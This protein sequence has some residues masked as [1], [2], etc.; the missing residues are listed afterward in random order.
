[1]PEFLTPHALEQFVSQYGYWAVFVLVG[2]ENAGIPLPGEIV[3]VAAAIDAGTTGHLR[4]LPV[5]LAAAGGGVL[6]GNVGY[7]LGREF[8][9][10]WLLRHGPRLGIGERQLKLGQY[11]FMRYG[12]WVVFFGRLVAVLRVLAALLAGVNRMRWSRFLLSNVGGGL[13]WAGLYGG[14]AY[15]LGRKVH[16]VTGPAGLVA[17]SL[18][19]IIVLVGWRYVRHHQRALEDA[20]E[21]AFPGPLE[22]HRHFHHH[23]RP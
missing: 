7:W 1:M 15:A 9:F 11:L 5:V 12:A 23:H 20:A 14:G 3:L 21:R 13:L 19:T 16:Q 2:L 8:G 18:A 22:A 17:L 4:I 6:G 10:R